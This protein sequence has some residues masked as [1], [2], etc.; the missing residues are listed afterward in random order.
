MACGI[1]FTD[2]G[3]NRDAQHWEPIVLAAGPPGES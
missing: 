1:Y 3:L 2:L